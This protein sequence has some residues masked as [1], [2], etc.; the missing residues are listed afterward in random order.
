[1]NPK[2]GN[3]KKNQVRN[4]SRTFRCQCRVTTQSSPPKRDS[5]SVVHTP[6]RLLSIAQASEYLSL[7]TWTIRELVWRGDVPHIRCGR[8]I[9]LDVHDLD[10]WIE[11]GKLEG[12]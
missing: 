5:A 10:A 3:Q 2:Q 11:R 4:G 12:I 9:L 1:L 8:R 6:R 7:S